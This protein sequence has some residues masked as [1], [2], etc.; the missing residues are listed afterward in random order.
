MSKAPRL[1]G[2]GG[3]YVRDAKGGLS[4]KQAT[5]PAKTNK[6]PRAGAKPEPVEGSNPDD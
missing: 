2:A 1:P 6:E 4:R 5:K 3:S